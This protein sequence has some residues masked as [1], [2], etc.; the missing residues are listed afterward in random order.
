MDDAYRALRDGNIFEMVWTYF[1]VQMDLFW[2]KNI[3][4]VDPNP[5]RRGKMPRE[6]IKKWMI[7]GLPAQLF[8]PVKMEIFLKWLGHILWSK[9]TDFWGAT[10]QPR[11]PTT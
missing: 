7:L 11:I 4:V 8:E 9:W 6:N 5:L 1:R 3:F 2:V 10:P